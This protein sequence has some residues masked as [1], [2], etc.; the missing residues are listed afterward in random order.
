MQCGV[1][2]AKYKLNSKQITCVIRI[3]TVL[4]LMVARKGTVLRMLSC[5]LSLP[6]NYG[7]WLR[8][9]KTSSYYFASWKFANIWLY[10]S[11]NGVPGN[12]TQTEFH[13]QIP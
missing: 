7:N 5:H 13:P 2:I 11:Y 6:C 9:Y 1:Q 10:S 3:Y 8:F 12:T 4:I